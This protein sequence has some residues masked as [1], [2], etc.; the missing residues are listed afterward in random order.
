M[1]KHNHMLS[2]RARK[3]WLRW[4]GIEWWDTGRSDGYGRLLRVCTRCGC[5]FVQ[6][7]CPSQA[8]DP[9]WPARAVPP[10]NR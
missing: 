7:L 9:D 2:W 3:G 1:A 5:S 4:R 6:P 8:C 10:V